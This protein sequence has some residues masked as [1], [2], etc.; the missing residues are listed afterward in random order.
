MKAQMKNLKFAFLLLP[1]LSFGQ[2][3]YA[4]ALQ[5]SIL[6]YEAQ[7]SGP[8]PSWNRVSWR[9]PS[10]LHDGSDNAQDLTGGWY[11]AGDNVKFN[12]PMAFSAT[13]LSWG[14]IENKAAY[15]ASG[16]LPFILNNIRFV[17]DYLIKCHTS[18]NE[19][20]GQVG[21]GSSD[22]AFWGPAESLELIMKRPS[23]KVDATHPGS[24]LAGETAAALAAAALVFKEL[25]P[26]YSAKLLLHAKQLYQFANTYKGVYSSAITDAA[27]YYRSWSG[28][29]DELVWSA[30]WLF[31]ATGDNTFLQAAETNYA[32][33]ATEPQSTVKS[34]KWTL[35]WDDKSNGCYVLLSQLTG[36]PIYKAD[37]ERWL[38]FWTVG[39]AGQKIA[40]TPGGQAW[41]D[42]W[43]SNRYAANTAF[44]AMV[45]AKTLSD[46]ALKNR[47]Q[48]FAENQ[49]N[50][51]L[52]N[53]PK[54]RSYLIGFGENPPQ[55]PHHRNAHGIY[56]SQAADTSIAK[57]ILYG[58]LVGGPGKDDSYVDDRN[59]YINNE[60]ACD[61]NAAFT[62]DLAAMVGL[63]GGK[64]LENFPPK[65]I[66]K[67]PE[68]FVT[69]SINV[70]GDRF[71]EIR[72]ILKNKSISPPR[73][74]DKLSFRFYLNL[75]ELA[76][77]TLTVQ[78][79]TVSK[80]YSQGTAT[81]SALKTTADKDIY[82]VDVDFSGDVLFPGTEESYRRE[83]QFRMGI[84]N[85]AATQN[86]NAD[87]DWSYT[88]LTAPNTAIDIDEYI[89]VY[90]SGALLFGR[91]YGQALSAN[92]KSFYSGPLKNSLGKNA[93][94]LQ[95]RI[96]KVNV[97]NSQIH[98]N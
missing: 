92:H 61:Y 42:T 29:E 41:L 59:N 66:Q 45:Y 27:G 64:A 6:F 12:F 32:K 26:T 43:G 76:A 17:A 28:Y 51:I 83:I 70:K 19:L 82:Y 85:N 8:V 1:S 55:R 94:N 44:C 21:N 58:A 35:A 3:N 74:M 30:I 2:F 36:K 56:P 79:V 13:M 47:Y 15:E 62:G 10:G 4:E 48:G 97:N 16:Q 49:I 93:Y 39:T 98:Y 57:H 72:A 81:V 63:H 90:N 38:D 34:F 5:K 60:V 69:A 23:Y 7:V 75:S 87:N 68:F 20:Y 37:A 86:W 9:G 84:P 22:H 11:D 14:V 18:E 53:N 78:D 91:E 88:G 50:Y 71:T 52:G 65:E 95:G 96:L 33:L 46:T 89:P 77:S 25:D 54:K 40:Y 31:K 73:A 67:S 24:D 80:N